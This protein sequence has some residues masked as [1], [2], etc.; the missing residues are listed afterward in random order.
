MNALTCLLERHPTDPIAYATHVACSRADYTAFALVGCF[1]TLLVHAQELKKE[2]YKLKTEEAPPLIILKDKTSMDPKPEPVPGLFR[3]SD[4]HDTIHFNETLIA[5]KAPRG[6]FIIQGQT[7]PKE[8]YRAIAN[9]I[10]GTNNYASATEL[11][12]RANKE[13]HA[14]A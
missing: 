9:A 1:E 5:T 7:P 4:Y 12:E 2:L 11:A 10:W 3:G 8:A 13:L 6:W 14:E